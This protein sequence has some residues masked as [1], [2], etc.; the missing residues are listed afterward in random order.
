MNK[1]R[2]DKS[3]IRITAVLENKLET[4]EM[5]LKYNHYNNIEENVHFY[6]FLDCKSRHKYHK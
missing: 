1:D 2:Y 4:V 3:I 6:C 5:L